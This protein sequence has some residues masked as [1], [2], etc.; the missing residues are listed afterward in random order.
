MSAA[1]PLFYWPAL[2]LMI[3]AL[4]WLDY[5]IERGRE[6][7]TKLVTIRV[8]C[9]VGLAILFN[10]F[11]LLKQ[12][13]AKALD[14]FTGYV[15]EYSLSVDNLFVFIMLF[16]YFKVDAGQQLKALQWGIYGAMVM[17]LVFIFFG[18][19]LIHLF[20]P[21]IYVFG[22]FLLWTSWKMQFGMDSHQDPDKL[23]LVK[24]FRRFIPV[25]Q[26]Y[27]G[28]RFF[29][30]Q[31]GKLLATPMVILVI[32]VESSDVMFAVDSIP[33]ILAITTDPFIV[34]SSNIFAILGLRALYFL[35]ARLVVIFR[36]LK[37][38]IAAILAFVGIKMLLSD[39]LHISTSIS[40][41][42][43]VSFLCGA[44]LWS[45]VESKFSASR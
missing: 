40:L 4:T 39:L 34:F 41:L 37:T 29:I 27:H 9:W 12:G 6:L 17:R 15:I 13:Q 33:A 32:A 26:S 7:T 25:T 21:I 2:I 30:R 31:N 3:I 45:V 38:G 11:I 20:H 36:R 42:M 8:L 5:R 22:L 14:F 16:E 19:T 44:I 43:I 35:L 24:A 23:P 28:T 10:L 18:I 1:E